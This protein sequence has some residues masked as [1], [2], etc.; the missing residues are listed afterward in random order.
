MLQHVALIGVTNL[1]S[2]ELALLGRGRQSLESSPTAEHCNSAGRGVVRNVRLAFCRSHPTNHRRPGRDIES[3]DMSERASCGREAA[4]SH[5]SRLAPVVLKHCEGGESVCA[6]VLEDM[7]WVH[8]R[9]VVKRRG[10]MRQTLARAPRQQL[11]LRVPNMRRPELGSPAGAARD[12]VESRRGR[13]RFRMRWALSLS[14]MHEAEQTW[15]NKFCLATQANGGIDL[16]MFMGRSQSDC[17]R[18]S[19]ALRKQP[20][21]RVDFAMA[22][23]QRC[24]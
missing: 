19:D 2:K 6:E 7:I 5:S 21:C 16:G 1:L 15:R 11:V 24:D 13:V 9:R 23:A 3:S 12:L 22:T 14:R 4:E 10:R 20:C 8:R 18:Q 17:H